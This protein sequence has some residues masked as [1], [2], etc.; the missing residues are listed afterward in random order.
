MRFKQLINFSQILEENVPSSTNI[1]NINPIL[2]I[3]PA[4]INGTFGLSCKDDCSGNCLN[5]KPCNSIDGTCS[6]CS[7]GWE[8]IW[9]NKSKTNLMKIVI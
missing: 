7:Q 1:T 8:N 3:F 2:S 4:C 9:C 5:E 6:F